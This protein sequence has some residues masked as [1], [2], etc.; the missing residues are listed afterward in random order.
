MRGIIV[1]L[2]LFTAL[3]TVAQESIPITLEKVLELSGAKN[4]TIQEYVQKQKLAVANV[5]RAKEWWLPNINVGAQANQLWG[6]VMNGN[7]K[8]FLDVERNNLGLGLGVQ[9]NWD[10]AQGIYATQGSKTKK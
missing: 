9:A 10:F 5:E 1:I 3:Q 6:A 2:V 8:F 4:L 7:G